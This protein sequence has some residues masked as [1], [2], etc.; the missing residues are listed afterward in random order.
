MKPR[1]R[2]AA[3]E[4]LRSNSREFLDHLDTEASQAES[5]KITSSEKEGVEFTEDSDSFKRTSKNHL[6]MS[7]E[8]KAILESTPELSQSESKLELDI[9][10]AQQTSKQDLS[11]FSEMQQEEDALTVEQQS[12]KEFDRLLSEN[13]ELID[14]R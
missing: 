8:A 5:L 9:S 3:S 2:L 13:K 7:P 1:K 12:V 4:A 6:F 11:L 10:A 14:L